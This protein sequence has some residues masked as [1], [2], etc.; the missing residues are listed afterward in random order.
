MHRRVPTHWSYKC[1]WA[2]CASWAAGKKSP[3]WQGHSPH[4]SFVPA[5][6]RTE[7][8]GPAQWPRGSYRRVWTWRLSC[9]KFSSFWTN[10][11]WAD[12]SEHHGRTA[13]TNSLSICS[14][15]CISWDQS[16][17]LSITCTQRQGVY[18]GKVTQHPIK[19]ITAL[20]S[21]IGPV[22][23]DIDKHLLFEVS[24]RKGWMAASVDWIIPSGDNTCKPGVCLQS[25]LRAE[26]ETRYR[27]LIFPQ[28]EHTGLGTWCGSGLL[29]HGPKTHG[30]DPF[31]P[32][33]ELWVW[34]RGAF[35]PKHVPFTLNWKVRFTGWLFG[36]PHAVTQGRE[37]N[38]YKGCGDRLL[39]QEESGFPSAHS[40]DRKHLVWNRT[41]HMSPG[42]Q[43]PTASSSVRV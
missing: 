17:Y 14:A 30:H 40:G 34:L 43:S 32:L 11:T 25:A 24:G 22:E 16:M 41:S 33:S 28:S 2:G 31:L 39:A 42:S 13:A 7:R 35:P 18:I 12:H 23:N 10:L 4:R 37:R 27:G 36:A 29:T 6:N 8:P 26:A 19:N 38:Q 9:S 15:V 21:F 5:A 20:L 3:G 1:G